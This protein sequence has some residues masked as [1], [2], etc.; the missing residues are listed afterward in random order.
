M[1]NASTP[2]F[3]SALMP[4]TV[5]ELSDM[6]RSTTEPLRVQGCGSWLHGGGPWASGTPLSTQALRGVVEYTPGDLVITVR[7]GTT[8][9]ELAEVTGEHAQMLAIAPYATQ[10]HALPEVPG[11]MDTTVGA[12]IATASAAPLPFADM[13]TRDLVLGVQVVTGD[14]AVTRA[15]GRVVKNVA[16]FDLVRLHTGAF[17]T[18][19]VI[20]EVSLRLHARPLHDILLRALL[21]D[22]IT[23]VIPRLVM[24]RAPLPMLLELPAHGEPVLWARCSGNVARAT[25]LEQRVREMGVHRTGVHHAGTHTTGASTSSQ[26]RWALHDNDAAMLEAL[27]ATPPD[28]VV[29][30]ARTPLSDAVPF[31]RAARDAFPTATLRFDPAAGSLRVLVPAAQAAALDRDIDTLYRLA[32]AG[33]AMH[34]IS[35]AIDQHRSTPRALT[36][37]EAKIKGAFDPRRVLNPLVAMPDVTAAPPS[38]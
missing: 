32:A 26:Q 14:G 33:G 10:R 3:A 25:A 37:L 17:G 38:S 11:L 22:P 23:D 16:G 9:A 21:R 34:T 4:A 36:P 35:V 12:M 7:A 31:V 29:L 18:L 13:T 15:G 8:L 2:A 5:H 27:R 19:G 6:V 20:T 24:Q 1:S 30:R 28:M